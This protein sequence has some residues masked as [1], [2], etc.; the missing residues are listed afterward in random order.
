MEGFGRIGQKCESCRNPSSQKPRKAARNRMNSARSPQNNPGGRHPVVGF[1]PKRRKPACVTN[2][3]VTADEKRL[4][5]SNFSA[6][7]ARSNPAA[8]LTPAAVRPKV[9]NPAVLPKPFGKIRAGAVKGSNRRTNLAPAFR[10]RG[11]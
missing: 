9:A 5:G 2:R 7:D 1:R 11:S 3:F 4:Q 8:A 10:R 6:S